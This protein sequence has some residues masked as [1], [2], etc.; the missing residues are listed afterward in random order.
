LSHP[1]AWSCPQEAKDADQLFDEIRHARTMPDLPLILLCSMEAGEP[2]ASGGGG[3]SASLPVARSRNQAPWRRTPLA[4]RLPGERVNKGQLLPV[5]VDVNNIDT[6][7]RLRHP[8]ARRHLRGPRRKT[9]AALG[10]GGLALVIFGRL[11]LSTLL[12]IAAVGAIV[13]AARRYRPK[14]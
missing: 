4:P 2:Q 9:L 13:A 5:L 6:R 10:L 8:P 11:T 7:D 14:K 12:V 1:H 3:G